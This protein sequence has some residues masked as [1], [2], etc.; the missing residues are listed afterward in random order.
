MNRWKKLMFRATFLGIV[1]VLAT[2]SLNLIVVTQSNG[3]MARPAIYKIDCAGYVEVSE[4]G[5]YYSFQ[6]PWELTL[7]YWAASLSVEFVTDRD[8][9]YYSH[10]PP[11][12]E[13]IVGNGRRISLNCFSENNPMQ[14]RWVLKILGDE[15]FERGMQF[16]KKSDPERAALL[17]SEASGDGVSFGWQAVL[18][19]ILVGLTLMIATLAFSLRRG[20]LSRAR[21]VQTLS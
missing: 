10:P 5:S 12:V 14:V 9:R 19:S 7:E 6:M 2:H 11:W 18:L 13:I 21:E 4:N 3:M 16:G 1:G 8:D 15:R 20:F 17:Q